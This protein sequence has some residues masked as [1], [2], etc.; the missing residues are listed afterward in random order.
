MKKC[1]LNELKVTSFSTSEA[2]KVSGGE[3]IH[4][5]HDCDLPY[6]HPGVC[7]SYANCP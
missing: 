1:R 4:T 7:G 3:W 5:V 2:K 6:S